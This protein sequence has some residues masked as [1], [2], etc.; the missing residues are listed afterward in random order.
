MIATSNAPLRIGYARE[1]KGGAYLHYRLLEML[2]GFL[3]WSTLILVCVLSYFKPV[4]VAVFIIAFDVY[5]LVKTAYL[6]IHLNASWRTMRQ[7]L[8]EDWQARL[9]SLGKDTWGDIWHMVILPFYNEPYEVVRDAIKSVDVADWPKDRMMIV[10]A[11][12]A[13]AG[14]YAA[15]IA[16][17]MKD[18][19]GGTFGEFIVTVHPDGIKGEMNGKGANISYAAREAKRR[20]DALGISIDR[21]IVS[22]F[23]IDTFVYPKYFMNLAYHFLTAA[24]PHR[25]S[26]QPIPLYNNN[27]WHAPAVSRV[28]ALSGTFWQMMQQ[29]RPERLTTFSSHAISLKALD[30][31]GYWQTNMVSEDSRIFW[32]CFM[33]F[34]GDYR[35]VPLFY[36]VS[37]DA[38]LAS[39]QFQTA[40]NVYK[41]QRRWT[42][43][44]ENLPYILY[45]FSKNPRI[46][47]SEKVRHTAIQLEGF[48]SLA[49]NPLLIF[50]LGWLPL[51]LGGQEFNTALV[52]YNL[53]R[54]TRLLMT[55][56]M[57]GLIG[58]ATMA[59]KL[60]PPRPR[61]YH[62][63]SWGL[64][65]L[66]WALIPFTIVIFGAL[67]G[68]DAQ[69][70]LMFGRYM[71]FWV[72]PKERIASRTVDS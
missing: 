32:N 70:R 63:F 36:P 33:A 47:F 49:T 24:H 50:L 22:A 59:V 53:P 11:T 23:D 15:G 13:R 52:A 56:A 19:F 61:E 2:P 14:G 1:L 41:Q 46:P 42:W 28:V 27:I 29:V 51:M 44:V 9:D 34:D 25:S 43:G 57:L 71:G 55:L 21:V 31:V 54:I 69:T 12:E 18:E 30:D 17:R 35:V 38:N 62:K 68:L 48:W 67:P 64:V 7:Y 8:K 37:M 58:S 3:S 40:V 60:M 20:I 4:W 26:Y 6:S 10:L 16:D 45:S 5:W 39:T 72:T 66:Q 65:V